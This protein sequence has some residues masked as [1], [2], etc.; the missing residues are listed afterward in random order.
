MSLATYAWQPHVRLDP[1]GTASNDAV[2]TAA[3][4]DIR[5]VDARLQRITG[6]ASGGINHSNAGAV[7]I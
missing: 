2:P 4:E 3:D 5:L 7:Y 6:W 1:S